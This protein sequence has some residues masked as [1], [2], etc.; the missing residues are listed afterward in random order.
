MKTPAAL[1]LSLVISVG[2]P[3]VVIAAPNLGT[4]NAPPDFSSGIW[5]EVFYGG[6][7]R[8][9]G[10]VMCAY[11]LAGVDVQWVLSAYLQSSVEIGFNEYLT[12]YSGLLT[13]NNGP[14]TGIGD[15]PYT[16]DMDN[17]LVH[18]IKG[19]QDPLAWTLTSSG[20]IDTFGLPVN[21]WAS[22]SG[23]PVFAQPGGFVMMWGSTDSVGMS[24][25][26]APGAFLL[27]SIGLSFVG[28]L[29]RRRTL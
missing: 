15:G 14:W 11:G 25:V 8:Q 3:C 29:R 26:P 1:C 12:T 9:L 21:V 20:L 22:Y 16:A 24:I 18:T 10:N 17:I 6:G 27:G 23:T 4:W 2:L 5:Y 13:L 19:G 7:E 28:W